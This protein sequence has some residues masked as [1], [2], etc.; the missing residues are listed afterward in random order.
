MTRFM[1]VDNRYVNVAK[2]AWGDRYEIIPSVTSSHLA[3]SVS[4]HPDMVL[5]PLKEKM[6]ICAPD[7]YEEYKKRFEESGVELICGEKELKSTYP[8]DIAYNILKTDNLAL[9][10]FQETDPV[11][12]KYLKKQKIELVNVNQGYTKCSVCVFSDCAIT[13]DSGIF[14]ALNKKGIDTLKIP[15]GEIKLKGYDYGFIGGASGENHEGEVFFFGDLDSVSYGGKI[16]E[17]ILSKGKTLCEIKN[18]PLT[19]VGTIMFC[20]IYK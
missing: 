11:I 14:S 7:C 16:R 9:G 8:C 19:D 17:F 2:R 15:C 4:A 1:I 18:Y 10:K 3:E 6:F 12:L 13:A 5:Y 20:W